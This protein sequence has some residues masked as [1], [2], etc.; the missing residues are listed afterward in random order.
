MAFAGAG[1]IDAVVAAMGAHGTSELVQEQGCKAL[2][3]LA[4]ND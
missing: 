3:T 1:V 2:A 4:V